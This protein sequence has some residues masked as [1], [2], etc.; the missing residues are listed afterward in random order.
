MNRIV[1]YF[2]IVC[3]GF[4]FAYGAHVSF[5][6]TGV[7]FLQIITCAFGC[8]F[9]G[10]IYDLCRFFCLGEYYKDISKSGLGIGALGYMGGLTFLFSSYYGAMDRIGDDRSDKLLKFRI[11]S[12]IPF[13]FNI[14]VCF[15]MLRLSIKMNIYF[16]I[17]TFLISVISYFAFKHMILPDIDNGILKS[18]RFYN[19]LVLT[20]CIVQNLYNIFCLTQ[21]ATSTF[22]KI[23]SGCIILAIMPSANRGVKKWYT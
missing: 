23:I 10:N 13:F 5:K 6:K 2:N 7:L 17:C 11:I 1:D 8:F 19:F 21:T 22:L 9:L 14:L 15:I 16:W 3:T 4:A 12:L 20:F 18:L